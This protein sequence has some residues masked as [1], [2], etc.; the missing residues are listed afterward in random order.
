MENKESFHNRLAPY[1]AP[2]EQLDVKLAYILAKFG[3]RAQQRKELTDGKPTRYFEHVRRVALI[4]TDE[5][6]IIER[7]MIIAGVLHDSY[8]DC[9]PEEGGDITPELLQHTFGPQVASMIKLLSKV[10][11]EGYHERL[12][13][14]GSWRVLCLKMADRLDNL[15]SLMVPG[16]TLE[17]QKRQIAETKEK[18]FPLFDQLLTMAPENYLANIRVV[19]DEIRRLVERYTVMIELKEMT[20]V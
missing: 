13:N 3:H 12:T 15:R 1:L 5:L 6:K 17:F 14:C 20:S 4:L 9:S 18:Y 19:R 7:D 8:E 2:S 16:T 10:P 11:K